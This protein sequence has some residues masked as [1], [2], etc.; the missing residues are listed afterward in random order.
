MTETP[1]C[2]TLAERELVAL[3]L[4]EYADTMQAPHHDAW[5]PDC[6][7]P[8]DCPRCLGKTFYDRRPTPNESQLRDLAWRIE[9]AKP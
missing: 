5:C 3:I 4:N 7:S 9:W 8:V 6:A 1:I 2:L